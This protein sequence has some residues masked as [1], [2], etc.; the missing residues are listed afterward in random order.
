MAITHV[1]LFGPVL[2]N[3]PRIFV[4]ASGNNN[5][6][7]F[8][9]RPNSHEYIPHSYPVFGSSRLLPGAVFTNPLMF[10]LLLSNLISIVKPILNVATN[11]CFVFMLYS[12]YQLIFLSFKNAI[13][14]III[15]MI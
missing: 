6:Y 9:Y 1:E 14:E 2:D 7:L 11:K 3:P 4:V 5:R 12:N 13:L 10:F 15:I 8:E